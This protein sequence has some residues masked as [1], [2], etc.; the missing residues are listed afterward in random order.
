MDEFE[1][2]MQEKERLLR[3]YHCKTI[4]EVIRILQLILAENNK[5]AESPM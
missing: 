3:K 5:K 2:I 1:A 4:N